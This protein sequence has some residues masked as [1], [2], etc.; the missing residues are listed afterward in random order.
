MQSMSE[1]VKTEFLVGGA[2]VANA[3]DIEQRLSLARRYLLSG[4]ESRERVTN[5]VGKKRLWWASKAAMWYEKARTMVIPLS[6]VNIERNEIIDSA[7]E[8]LVELSQVLE[9]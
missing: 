8:N 7:T 4:D 5:S 3:R 6:R 9:G 2:V 1:R